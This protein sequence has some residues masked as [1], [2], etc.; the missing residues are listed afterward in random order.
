L[1]FKA[2]LDGLITYAEHID[3]EFGKKCRSAFNALPWIE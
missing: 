1:G 3:V 2:H